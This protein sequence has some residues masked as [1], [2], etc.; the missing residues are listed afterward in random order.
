MRQTLMRNDMALELKRNNFDSELKRNGTYLT[1]CLSL[2]VT[3]QAILFMYRPLYNLIGNTVYM[4]NKSV[5][6]YTNLNPGSNLTKKKW[7]VRNQSDTMVRNQ[8]K[9]I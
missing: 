4:F 8:T 1:Y 3:Q 5:P 7:N 6:K 9:Y 2:H